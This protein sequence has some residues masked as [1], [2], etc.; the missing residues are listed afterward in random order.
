MTEAKSGGKRESN[1]L[2]RR[3]PVPRDA[4]AEQ[5]PRDPVRRPKKTPAHD[6]PLGMTLQEM[7]ST[8]TGPRH[9]H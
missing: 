4:A 1:A 5:I 6:G 9:E 2:A 3:L 7:R 8:I